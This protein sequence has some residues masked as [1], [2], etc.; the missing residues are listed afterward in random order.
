[1]TDS[2]PPVVLIGRDIFPIA[3]ALKFCG[4]L[5]VKEFKKFWTEPERDDINGPNHPMFDKIT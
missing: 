4:K 5:V 1:M 3:N 2:A